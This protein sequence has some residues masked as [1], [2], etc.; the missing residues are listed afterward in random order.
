MERLLNQRASA[1]A[2]EERGRL[3]MMQ[4]AVLVAN[5]EQRCVAIGQEWGSV[6]AGAPSWLRSKRNWKPA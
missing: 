6:R 4:L 1:V 3:D 5:T 2:E